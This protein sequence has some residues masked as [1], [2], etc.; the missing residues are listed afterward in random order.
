MALNPND[1]D[2]L[3]G[4]A[5][6]LVWAGRPEEAVEKIQLAM[7]LNPNHHTSYSWYLGHAYFLLRRYDA[8]IATLRKVVDRSP[9]FWPAHIYL[10]ASYSLL[11]RMEEARAAAAAAL[12]LNPTITTTHSA[13]QIPYKNPADHKRLYDALEKAGLVPQS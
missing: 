10:A 3:A 9:D 11:G 4:L 5:D 13:G 12:R 7:R 8:A 1:A 6:R 2:T